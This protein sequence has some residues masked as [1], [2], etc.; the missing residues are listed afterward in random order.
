VPAEGPTF[1]SND[2]GAVGASGRA[3]V[4]GGVYTVTG[5]GVDVWGTTDEFQFFS[6]TV[7]GDFDFSARAASVQNVDAWTKAG[8]MI[9]EGLAANAR[10]AFLIQTPSTAKGIAFQR[11]PATG[12]TSVH[13]AGPAT[14]PPRWLRLVRA[15]NVIT[16]YSKATST[17]AWTPIGSQTFTTLAA[18]LRVGLAVGS[19]IDGTLATATFDNLSLSP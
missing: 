12:G 9:R 16:A 4:S 1:Q 13:T 2:V 8:L 18:T 17:D 6:R 14:G 3:V 11:R 15:G 7:T 5:S 10:H 19:H